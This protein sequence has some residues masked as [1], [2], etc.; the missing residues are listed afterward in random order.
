MKRSGTAGVVCVDE[1]RIAEKRLSREAQVG[2]CTISA[3][4]TR[5][6]HR[7]RS[8]IETIAPTLTVQV[9]N[10]RVAHNVDGKT[11]DFRDIGKI[12]SAEGNLKLS[13]IPESL[14]PATAGD[15]IWE[16]TLEP[17]VVKIVGA[18]PVT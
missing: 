17:L 12:L 5:Y 16:S 7:R 10:Q 6:H 15:E 18:K 2:R 3:R 11:I 13:R 4:D 8:R 9:I 1:G 14:H